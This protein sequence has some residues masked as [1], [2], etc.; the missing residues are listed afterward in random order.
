MGGESSALICCGAV[1]GIAFVTLQ[2]RSTIRPMK[3][4]GSHM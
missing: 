2:M 3:M 1:F 4:M